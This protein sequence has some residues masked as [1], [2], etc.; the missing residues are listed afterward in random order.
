MHKLYETVLFM[1]VDCAGGTVQTLVLRL[2]WLKLPT[3]LE[4]RA[5]DVSCLHISGCWF[6]HMPG[7]SF[8]ENYTWMWPPNSHHI[9]I[10]LRVEVW[11]K[12]YLYGVAWLVIICV[13][14]CW[15]KDKGKDKTFSMNWI[16]RD[17]QLYIKEATWQKQH[18]C[19]ICY[20][21]IAK[22]SR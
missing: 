13:S 10:S 21:G 6:W 2:G 12:A 20:T 14:P 7:H 1:C 18:D 17:T 15:Y 11:T 19:V 9:T 16:E 5:L 4:A 3:L 22:L 8:H